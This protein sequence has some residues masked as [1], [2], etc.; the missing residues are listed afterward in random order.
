[1]THHHPDHY[2]SANPILEAFPTA[3]FYA[4]IYVC[5]GID[6]EYDD[7]VKFWPTV[8]CKENVPEAPRR[9]DPY[10]YSFVVLYG[11]PCS[12]IILVGPAQGDSVDHTLFWLRTEKTIITGD[13]LYGRRTHVWLEFLPDPIL[14]AHGANVIQGGRN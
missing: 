2:F 10:P 8:F 13:A 6:R 4:A 11:N 7:K 14:I 1:V 5:A 9:P 3:A 12:P